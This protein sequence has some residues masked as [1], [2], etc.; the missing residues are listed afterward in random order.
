[1]RQCV[2]IITPYFP[3]VI[4]EPNWEKALS[5]SAQPNC[6]ASSRVPRHSDG[7][8]AVANAAVKVC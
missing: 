4:A 1:M 8:D 5:I 7:C 2:E 3:T 6:I